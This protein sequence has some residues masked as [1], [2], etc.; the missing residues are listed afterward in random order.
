MRQTTLEEI[1][2]IIKSFEMDDAIP[3]SWEYGVVTRITKDEREKYASKRCAICGSDENVDYEKLSG[4]R[5]NLICKDCAVKYV[6]SA[7]R[8]MLEEKKSQPIFEGL[9]GGK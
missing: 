5:F 3:F 2:A 9:T 4:G 7:K 1:D 8:R 6:K